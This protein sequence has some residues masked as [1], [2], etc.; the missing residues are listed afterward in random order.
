VSTI[1]WKEGGLYREVARLS[2]LIQKRSLLL[3][4]GEIRGWD[5]TKLLLLF[6]EGKKRVHL[7]RRGGSSV[8]KGRAPPSPFEE[9]GR[10]L[11]HNKTLVNFLKGNTG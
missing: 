5:E 9:R 4:E 8:S 6:R 3:P 2:I 10:G 11:Q 7:S 1:T